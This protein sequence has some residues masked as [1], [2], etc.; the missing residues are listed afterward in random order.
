[1]FDVLDPDVLFFSIQQMKW[2]FATMNCDTFVS[3]L[4]HNINRIIEHF[5]VTIVYCG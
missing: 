4:H 1:M 3:E 5:V 2:V